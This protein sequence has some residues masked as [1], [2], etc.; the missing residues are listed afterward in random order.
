[1]KLSVLLPCVVLAALC[2]GAFAVQ[3]VTP[4]T[5]APPVTA[6]PAATGPAQPILPPAPPP[7]SS[8]EVTLLRMMK[9]G[10]VI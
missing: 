3:T 9:W 5:A 6:Q 4:S 7:A 2:G 10:G 1:M 8:E